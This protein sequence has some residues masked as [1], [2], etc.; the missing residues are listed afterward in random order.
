LVEW[1]TGTCECPYLQDK[2][3]ITTYL[4]QE[5]MYIFALASRNYVDTS[6]LKFL[7]SLKH[8]SKFEIVHFSLLKLPFFLL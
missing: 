2:M 8:T 6:L 1:I 3:N 7:N 4:P 5:T